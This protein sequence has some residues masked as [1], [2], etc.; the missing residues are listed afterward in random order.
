M[1]I[2]FFVNDVM[3]EQ[4]GYTTIRLAM[5]AT[6]RG[7]QVWLI[8]AGD[9]TCDVKN[10]VNAFAFGPPKKKYTTSASYLNDLQSER[11]VRE[12]INVDNLDVLMLRNDPLQIRVIGPGLKRPVLLLARWRCGKGLL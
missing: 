7:H 1:K 11:A 8:G 3:T 5:G 10:Q 12:H 4:T 2:A 9:F 6:N